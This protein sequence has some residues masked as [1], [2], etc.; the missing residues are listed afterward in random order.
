MLLT[1]PLLQKIESL[2]F[3]PFEDVLGVGHS[4]GFSSLVW[5]PS[6]P[7]ADVPWLISMISHHRSSLAPVNPT[8]I[9]LKPTLSSRAS[10]A[11]SKKSRCCLIRLVVETLLLLQGVTHTPTPTP[12]AAATRQ[13]RPGSRGNWA[14]RYRGARCEEARNQ[15]SQGSR[16]RRQGRYQ[17][18]A[19]DERTRRYCS[20]REP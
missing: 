16:A 20:S 2:C 6:A 1:S 15:V 12:T 7:C 17:N 10:S 9:P 3:R 13:H 4:G 8:L 5:C 18:Q 14:H 19:K 11:G